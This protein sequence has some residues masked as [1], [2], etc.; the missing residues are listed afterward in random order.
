[1][2]TDTFLAII[3]IIVG[4][5]AGS[6][7]TGYLVARMR[8]IDIQKVGSGNIG[9]TNVLRNMGVA[10]AIIVVLIDP[11]KGFLVTLFPLLIG[12]DAW[13][14]ALTGVATILGNH[15]NIFLKLRGGKGVATSLGVF[16]AVEPLITVLIL[17]LGITTIALGR[18]VSLGS[19]VGVLAAPLM[20]LARGRFVWPY[21]ALAVAIVLL[22][23]YKHRDNIQRLTQ[24]VERRLGDSK[25]V[26]E[27][28]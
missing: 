17:V 8:G 9:A 21:F 19:L 6:I 26:R 1:M 12:M 3:F 18:M 25:K 2:V 15:Y 28:P 24:G 13:I 5:L 14:V 23:F 7:P 11:L 16:L 10:P 20:L 22:T 27:I 4:Y